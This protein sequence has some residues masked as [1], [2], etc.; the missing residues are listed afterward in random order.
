M[1]PMGIEHMIHM[2]DTYVCTKPILQAV[3]CFPF[4][5]GK[6][7]TLHHLK[8]YFLFKMGIFHCYVCLPEGKTFTCH[9]I[10]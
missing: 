10:N 4:F 2:F 6:V 8:M 9:Q 5:Y 3:L 7:V 1:N